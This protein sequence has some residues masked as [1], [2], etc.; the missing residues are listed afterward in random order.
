MVLFPNCNAT[1]YREIDT[2]TVIGFDDNQEPI[3]L[4]CGTNGFDAI[5]HCLHEYI[6]S[7]GDFQSRKSSETLK[8][9]GNI[10]Q[11]QFMLF[12]DLGVDIKADDKVK[13]VKFRGSNNYN[14]YYQVIGD[15]EEFINIRPHIEV[16]LMK[17]RK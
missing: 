15:P 11:S 3:K 13:I 7:V 10:T 9:F 17:E 6:S 4:D 12:L 14:G 5:P 8:D 16:T 1:V 2:G